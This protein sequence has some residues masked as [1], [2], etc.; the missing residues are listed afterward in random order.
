MPVSLRLRLSQMDLGACSRHGG[1]RSL[2]VRILPSAAGRCGPESPLECFH[3]GTLGC[4][5]HKCLNIQHLCQGVCSKTPA[6]F[7]LWSQAFGKLP[8]LFPAS[9]FSPGLPAPC[10]LGGVCSL[11]SVFFNLS[12]IDV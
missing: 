2:L 10:N 8:V 7:L 6:L 11:L 4:S 5:R 3:V 9:Y 12:L 1:W